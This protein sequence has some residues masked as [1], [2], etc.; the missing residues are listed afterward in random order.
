MLFLKVWLSFRQQLVEVA[1]INQI[2]F[3]FFLVRVLEVK[4]LGDLSP[5]WDGLRHDVIGHCSHLIGCYQQ[6][7]AELDK[8]SSE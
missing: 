2:F 1:D 7:Q 4:E 8:L 3:F 5:H 6:T